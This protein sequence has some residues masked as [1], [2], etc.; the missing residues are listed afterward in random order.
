MMATRA[1]ALDTSLSAG[2]AVTAGG[3][4]QIREIAA[5]HAFHEPV[6][7]AATTSGFGWRW[8]RMHNGLDFG[9]DIG[10]PLYAVAQGT[11]TTSGWNSGLGNH[12]KI[13]L[14]SGE[15]VVYGHMSQID[16]AL[17]DTVEAGTMIGAVGNT[18]RST[19]AHLHLEIRTD[20]GPIDPAEWLDAR[21]N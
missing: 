9:A 1:A 18:G 12:V 6:L 14:G 4:V 11:V 5:A 17:D 7:D 16:V 3:A 8:G 13:T 21:R 2:L 20:D 19:G 10:A 15:V